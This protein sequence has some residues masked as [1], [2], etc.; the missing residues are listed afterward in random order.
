MNIYTTPDCTG[1]S[2]YSIEF[3]SGS[4]NWSPEITQGTCF[5]KVF[6]SDGETKSSCVQVNIGGT[7]TTTHQATTTM[8]IVQTTPAP[9]VSTTRSW[10]ITTRTSSG[11]TTIPGG[12]SRRESFRNL[13]CRFF[14]HLR[15]C[16]WND[17]TPPTQVTP[18]PKAC[19][20]FP[21]LR[22]CRD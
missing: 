3:S 9:R 8:I 11:T 12:S 17:T 18:R 20:F 14:P 1:M 4:A 10:T 5:L 19:R 21:F 6:C 2:D 7:T 16:Q 15:I 13:F 22:M